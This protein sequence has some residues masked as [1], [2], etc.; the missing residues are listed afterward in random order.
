M[1][2]VAL[3]KLIQKEEAPLGDLMGVMVGLMAAFAPPEQRKGM[4]NN[5]I[6]WIISQ[7]F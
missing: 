4:V 1:T 2:G 6:L 3:L 5:F 7:C